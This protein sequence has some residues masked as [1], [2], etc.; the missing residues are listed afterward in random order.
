MTMTADKMA[1]VRAAKSTLG[2]QE[3]K[4]LLTVEHLESMVRWHL[5]RDHSKVIQVK[6]VNQYNP[7]LVVRLGS[8]DTERC[9]FATRVAPRNWQVRF[10][11]PTPG[12]R[13]ENDSFKSRPGYSVQEFVSPDGKRFNAYGMCQE[14]CD[15]KDLSVMAVEY[16]SPF[17]AVKSTEQ[18]TVKPFQCLGEIPSEGIQA[19]LE[20]GVPAEHWT[21]KRFVS[22]HLWTF[23]VLADT[24]R[25]VLLWD[26]DPLKG[27][28]LL[29]QSTPARDWSALGFATNVGG[30]I[31]AVSAYFANDQAAINSALELALKMETLCKQI[32]GLHCEYVWPGHFYSGKWQRFLP[33]NYYMNEAEGRYVCRA[34]VPTVGLLKTLR[35]EGR[36]VP[37]CIVVTLPVYSV[38]NAY[39]DNTHFLG[40]GDFTKTPPKVR[41]I[42]LMPVGSKPFDNDLNPDIHDD[43]NAIGFTR[44]CNFGGSC[45]FLHR[46]ATYELQHATNLRSAVAFC[47]NKPSDEMVHA[48]WGSNKWTGKDSCL[49]DGTF[50]G[51]CYGWMA[52]I[53]VLVTRIGAIVAEQF[54][55]NAAS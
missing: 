43:A 3:L 53:D 36:G 51:K 42:L 16:G 47:M 22:E 26:K 9:L 13:R 40:S 4:D 24:E 31:A 21:A 10:G 37:P 50:D 25:N 32:D 52:D 19:E 8:P 54:F 44:R 29:R 14:A 38:R 33:D 48:Y 39:L 7:R 1:S 18:I 23:G 35:C 5:G 17:K 27:T 34:Q 15:F 41:Q 30:Y 55:A 28:G 2:P 20:Q 6:S 12:N 11:H 46:G 49:P 45:D